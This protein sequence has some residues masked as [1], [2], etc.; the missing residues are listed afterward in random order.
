MGRRKY[1]PSAQTTARGNII[2][3]SNKTRFTARGLVNKSTVSII[4]QSPTK[5]PRSSFT[6]L[7]AQNSNN[8]IDV[9]SVLMEPLQLPK[10]KVQN[11]HLILSRYTSLINLMQSQNDYMWE[12]LS[13]RKFYL[14]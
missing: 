5:T 4:Q 8:R 1:K 6:T 7:H 12:Y 14:A 11:L 3:L 2:I 10:S 13:K 9:D